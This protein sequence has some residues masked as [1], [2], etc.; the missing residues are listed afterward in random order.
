MRAYKSDENPQ[1][2]RE[3]VNL[4][5][6]LRAIPFY[7]IYGPELEKPITFDGLLSPNKIQSEI[8]KAMEDVSTK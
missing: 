8:M 7:A 2:E 1:V 5:N 4:G 3:L 6:N